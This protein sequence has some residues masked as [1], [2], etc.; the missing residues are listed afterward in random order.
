ML[1]QT[2]PMAPWLLGHST[3]C[4]LFIL[5]SLCEKCGCNTTQCSVQHYTAHCATLHSA[6][7]NT[8]QCSVVQ[9]CTVVY[10]TTCCSVQTQGGTN[11][12][13]IMI[14]SQGQPR[15]PGSHCHPTYTWLP[16]HATLHQAG[17][18]GCLSRAHPTPSSWG[19]CWGATI[20]AHRLKL[21]KEILQGRGNF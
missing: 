15:L 8:T 1:A 17:Y 4:A 14:S 19:R 12:L 2:S 3:I 21:K 20:N 9:H 5:Q 7:C 11:H 13:A 18:A 10:N 16:W 6:L